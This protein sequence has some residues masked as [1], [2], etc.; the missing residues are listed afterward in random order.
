MCRAA[1]LSLS[2]SV[3]SSAQPITRREKC[4]Q[5]HRQIDE[6]HLQPDIGVVGYP[7]CSGV[8]IYI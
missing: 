3:S 5:N 6:L 8:V 7:E 4:I 2:S 1:R